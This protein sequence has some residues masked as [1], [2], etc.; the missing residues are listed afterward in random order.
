MLDRHRLG[1]HPAHRRTDDVG[2]IDVE[3]VEQADAVVAH[4]RQGVRHVGHRTAGQRRLQGAVPVGGDAVELGR[5]PAVAIVEADDVATAGGEQ[6]AE[7]GVPARQLH[8]EAGD[9]QHGWIGGRSERLVLD[10]DE[11]RAR[12]LHGGPRHPVSLAA[13]STFRR[14]DEIAFP[15]HAGRDCVPRPRRPHCVASSLAG[16]RSLATRS[17]V[18]P[19]ARSL[20]WETSVMTIFGVHT[21]SAEHLGRRAAGWRGAASRSSGSTGSRSGTTS[22][23][24]PA[25]PTTPTASRR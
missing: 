25:M 15:G 3:S 9:E 22:T 2:G 5:Q 16:A 19:G 14:H 10:L 24:P 7:L 20:A 23:A 8:D 4:V 13:A 11:V 17:L 21:G 18:H 6:L 1:D 12:R